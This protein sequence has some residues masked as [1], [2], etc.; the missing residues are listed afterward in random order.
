MKGL[1][2]LV[3]GIFL[4]MLVYADEWLFSTFPDIVEPVSVFA[5]DIGT[6]I[7]LIGG[8][9]AII[10]AVF[11]SLPIWMSI[12]LFAM[13]MYLGGYYLKD[14]TISVSVTPQTIS[15]IIDKK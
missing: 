5:N 10:I 4:L 3:I 12:P 8:V 11:S 7:L 13:L 15:I 2:F 6:D 1:A 9:V 14:K